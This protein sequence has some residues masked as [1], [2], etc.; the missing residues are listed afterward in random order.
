MGKIYFAS[1]FHLGIDAQT[2]SREREKTIVNWL[3]EISSDAE[4]LYLLGDLFD[5]WFEYKTVV[6]RGYT[7]LLGK[8]ASL[9]D[10]GLPIHIFTG[11]HDMW[12]FGYFQDELGIPVYRQPIITRFGDKKFM[13]GHGDGLGPGDQGYKLIKQIFSSPASQ[14][15]Y[16]RL[17]P[18]LAI[19]LM[20]YFSGQSREATEQLDFLGPEKEWLIQFCEEKAKSTEIDYYIFGHRHLPID[21]TLHTGKSRYINL[22]DWLRY[23]SYA[24]FDGEDVQLRF[25]GKEAKIIS[26]VSG[27]YQ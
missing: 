1:D 2:T 17:H 13:L 11:N 23:N 21:W 27:I 8:L 19:R 22:G 14:W 15:I 24:V 16:A 26:N 10:E 5:Y 20:R 3:D 18:N 6:P 12:M 25:Y 7:R 9:K 4:E